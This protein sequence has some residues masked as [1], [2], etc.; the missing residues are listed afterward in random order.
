MAN[1]KAGSPAKEDR[2]RLPEKIEHS[3]LSHTPEVGLES[4]NG[5]T[6]PTAK[7]NTC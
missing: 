2:H 1:E 5:A 4:T 3:V 7:I 6:L